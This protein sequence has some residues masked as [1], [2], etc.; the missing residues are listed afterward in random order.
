MSDTV[1]PRPADHSRV[2]VGP[3]VRV[4]SLI[5]RLGHDPG[6]VLADVGMYP[7]LLSDPDNAISFAALCRLLDTCSRRLDCAHFGVLLGEQV[8]LHHLGLLGV[9]VRLSRDVGEALQLLVRHQGFQTRLNDLAF[10]VGTQQVLLSY[11][12]PSGVN[13]GD[14]VGDS[15]L[16]GLCSLLRGLCGSGWSPTEVRFAHRMPRELADFRR[17]FRCPLAFSA[18][19]YALAFPARHLAKSLANVEPE[20]LDVVARRVERETFPS[21]PDFAAHVGETIETAIRSGKVSST[22]VAASLGVHV[23]TL[24]RRLDSHG[25]SFQAMLDEARRKAATRM[26]SDPRLPIA[27]ISDR[28]GYANSA[29]FI[30]AFRRWHG[31]TPAVWRA[32]IGAGGQ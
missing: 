22:I 20:L 18:S 11:R 28:L 19:D 6:T 12:G 16:A 17:H 9:L 25:L 2:R 1:L 7:S 15:I 4:P 14:Q 10:E 5:G 26:L 30:R 29:S 21:C 24:S 27:Q 8:E 31:R 13:G 23:R 3:L 32:A